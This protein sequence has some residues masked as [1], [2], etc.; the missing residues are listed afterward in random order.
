LDLSHVTSGWAT[1]RPS[2]EHNP[3]GIDVRALD[4]RTFLL[5]T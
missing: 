1:E 4:Q 3:A 2:D 5:T